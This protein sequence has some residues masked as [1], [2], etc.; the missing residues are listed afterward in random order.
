MLVYK[1]IRDLQPVEQSLKLTDKTI[2]HSSLEM[3]H[4]RSPFLMLHKA[5][6]LQIQVLV[7]EDLHDINIK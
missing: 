7:V 1:H 3:L 6:Y 5:K 2:Y 4:V